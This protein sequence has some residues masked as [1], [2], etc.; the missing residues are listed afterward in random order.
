MSRRPKRS[1]QTVVCTF[2]KPSPET[3][4]VGDNLLRPQN[5]LSQDRK[6]LYKAALMTAK[7]EVKLGQAETW[8]IWGSRC[9]LLSPDLELSDG[10]Q[11]A[12]EA[13][14]IRL[15]GVVVVHD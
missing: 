1:V 12:I 15:G 14:I 8:D 10:R 11:Q 9:I 4:E 6:A 13:G 2:G 5:R 3:G 7:Q